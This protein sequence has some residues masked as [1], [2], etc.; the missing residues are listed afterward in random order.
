MTLMFCMLIN[1]KVYYLQVDTIF[2]YEFHQACSKYIDK[3]ALS[4]QYL[5]K[6][7]RNKL[8][9]LQAGKHNSFP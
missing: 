8:Q 7:V 3:F 5:K 4:L 9:F 6:E 1:I 2:F